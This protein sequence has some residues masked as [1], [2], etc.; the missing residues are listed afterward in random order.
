MT[1]AQEKRLQALLGQRRRRL[2]LAYRDHD[3]VLWA[4]SRPV[5]QR[6]ARYDQRHRIGMRGS[7]EVYI[8]STDGAPD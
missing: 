7:T 6:N 5:G 2:V 1:D 8:E 4:V 3:N